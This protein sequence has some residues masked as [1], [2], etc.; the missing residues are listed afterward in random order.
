[1][2]EKGYLKAFFVSDLHGSITRYTK[3]FSQ[4][5]LERPSLL[6]MGGDLLPSQF[7]SFSDSEQICQEF[8]NDFLA[9][10][11][12]RLKDLLGE[13]FPRVFLILGNDDPGGNEEEI[14][15]GEKK[16]LWEYVN[17]RKV[18]HAGYTIYGYCYVP[19][20]PFLLKDW[21][22]YDVSRFT[23]PGC[24][25][26]LEGWHSVP[27]EESKLKYATIKDDLEKL[28]RPGDMSRSVFLFHAPPYRTNLD[29]AGLD[30][31]MVDRVPLDVHVGSIAIKEFIEQRQP[32]L[33]M[34]GHVHESARITR[35]WKDRIG[36]TYA[37][38]AAHDGPELSVVSFPLAEPGRAERKLV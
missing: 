30:G 12:I 18:E 31:K 8:I 28:A 15:K 6:F 4:V 24:V 20:T 29:R 16:G 10:G 26:P 32:L 13:D 36:S 34:H 35:S 11:F 23:D 5:A 2:I 1:M 14:I 3:L 22:R 33:T 19:P 9:P 25:D 7:A 37:F 27:F 21:E 17:N 38:T